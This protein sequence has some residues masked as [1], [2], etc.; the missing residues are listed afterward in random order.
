MPL[1]AID[2][3]CRRNGKPDCT[4]AGGV[5][6]FHDHLV[7]GSYYRQLST[8]EH[9][10]TNQRGELLA[11]LLALQYLATCTEEA[12]I[13]T[14]SEYLFNAMTKEW[15]QR[16]VNNGWKTA[17]GEPVKN[18]DLW[19]QIYAAQQTV[20]CEVTYVHIKGHV[21]PFGDV[22]ARTL[23]DE[24]PSCEKLLKAVAKRFDEL[25]PVKAGVLEKAQQ[26]SVKNNGFELPR[27]IFKLCVTCNIVADTIATIA[28][29]N[30][31]RKI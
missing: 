13:I 16:W 10:S 29:D 7:W 20:P 5:F 22:T 17:A 31:D 25:A 15:P 3:A 9:N 12:N 19:E 26:L 24:D 18:A 8:S 14:D 1:I 30:A 27:D 4:A 23:V 28:V 11:L 2:G 6:V 21:I